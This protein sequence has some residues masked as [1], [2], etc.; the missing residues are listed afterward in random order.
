MKESE[1]I[2]RFAIIG[3]LN[4][5]LTALVVWVMMHLLRQH[6]RISNI[7]AYLVAQTNNFLWC[8][9]WVFPGHKHRSMSRQIIL[10]V[11]V[12]FV[13]YLTQLLFV[14]FLV[15]V[16]GCNAYWAQFLGLVVYGAVTFL[17]NQKVTFK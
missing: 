1:H 4:F 12:F 17:L 9:A 15:E 3:F 7:V 11:L 5:L 6:Y 2:L 10:F 14:V 8:R 13:A 16:I